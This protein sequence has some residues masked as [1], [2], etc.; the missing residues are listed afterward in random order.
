MVDSNYSIYSIHGVIKPAYIAGKH[1]PVGRHRRITHPLKFKKN[2]RM[3]PKLTSMF[4]FLGSGYGR[5][6]GNLSLSS[7]RNW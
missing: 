7:E 2:G 5:R 4:S 1:H 3:T 6:N